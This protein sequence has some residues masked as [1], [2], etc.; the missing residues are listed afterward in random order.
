MVAKESAKPTVPARRR[1]HDKDRYARGLGSS[2]SNASRPMITN[3]D[4]DGTATNSTR[5]R[6]PNRHHLRTPAGTSTIPFGLITVSLS[7]RAATTTQ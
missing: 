6:S 2:T 4:I 5:S 1:H 7:R 3:F